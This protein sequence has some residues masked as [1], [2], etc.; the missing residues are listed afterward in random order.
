VADV[1]VEASEPAAGAPDHLVPAHLG[2]PGRP[3]LAG[4]L[5]QRD[6]VAVAA[7]RRVPGGQDEV[8]RIAQQLMAHQAGGQPPG[9]VLPLVTQHEVDVAQRQRGQR[10]LGLGLDHLAAQLR[11]VAAERVHRRQREAQ[12]RGLE[13]GDAGAAGDGAGGRGQVGLGEGRALE[14]RIGVAD[15]DEGGIGQAHAPPGALEQ[16]YAGLALEDREL[17]GDGRRRELQ[18]VRDR[19]DRP[20]LAELAQQAEASEVEHC[21]GTLLLFVQ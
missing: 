6:G 13:A 21:V 12:R 8:D 3:R 19:G 5:G 18:G 7:R 14:Q 4:Q 15:Q 16:R 9:L 11:R 1:G 17:L 2:V 10:I 20:A